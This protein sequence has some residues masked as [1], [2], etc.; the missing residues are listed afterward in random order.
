MGSATRQALAASRLA[1]TAVGGNIDLA[2]DGLRIGE[3]LFAAA[4]VV[5]DSKQLRQLLADP[6][7]EADE[8]KAVVAKVFGSRLSTAVTGLLATVAT[9]RW[10]KPDDLLGGIEELGLRAVAESAGRGT[11]IESELFAFSAAVST[12]SQ[13][14]LAVGSRLGDPDA[15]VALVETLLSGKVS[16]QTVAIVRHLVRQPRGRRIGP[17]LAQAAAIVADQ[18]NMHV[19]T[20]TTAAPLA[21]AQLERLRSKLSQSYGR[22]LMV[23]QVVDAAVLGGVKV[24]IGD[25]IIDGSVLTRLQDLRLQLAS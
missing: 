3:E 10:S 12:D 23:N 1:L 17:S 18:A 6:S 7:T 11:D 4:H 9:S 5:S 25:D 24:Q 19:A 13:L 15:K 20:I 21:S 2:K 22:E 14:E 8:K 16:E